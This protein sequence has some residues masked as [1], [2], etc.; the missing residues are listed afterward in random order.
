MVKKSEA[1][2]ATSDVREGHVCKRHGDGSWGA[3][4]G[5]GVIGAAI[6]FVGQ[7]AGFW[8][9]VLALLKSIVWPVFLVY[10]LLRFL[11]L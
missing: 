9:I 11:G 2:K 7:A 5:L 4:Y 8:S 10:G 3:Y 6:Y 1:K